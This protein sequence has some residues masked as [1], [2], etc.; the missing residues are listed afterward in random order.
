M[1]MKM[2]RPKAGFA[3]LLCLLVAG[4]GKQGITRSVGGHNFVVPPDHLIR[5]NIPWLPASQA[6]GVMFIVNPSD[7]PQRQII[8]L[9]QERGQ[10]C[11]GAANS[12]YLGSLCGEPNDGGVFENAN[13]KS[14]LSKTSPYKDGIESFY[15]SRSDPKRY[16]A[17][18]TE[19]ATPSDLGGLCSSASSYKNLKYT[20]NFREKAISDLPGLMRSATSLLQSW[21]RG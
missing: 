9:L 17:I 14:D 11:A 3:L 2:S 5:S 6:D 4:C 16:I 19:P 1:I 10:V 20:I 8:V 12:A 15:V 18:C 13:Y 7:P 21:E